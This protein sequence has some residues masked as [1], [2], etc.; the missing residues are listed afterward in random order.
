MFGRGGRGS[1]GIVLCREKR[2]KEDLVG[3]FSILK[4]TSVLLIIRYTCVY[5]SSSTMFFRD[6][7]KSC[8]FWGA[9]SCC[10]ALSLVVGR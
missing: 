5:L 10:G 7:V 1:G 8:G 6:R 3:T 4:Y 2:G 9:E